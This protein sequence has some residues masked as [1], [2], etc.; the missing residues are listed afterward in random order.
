MET[1]VLRQAKTGGQV[2]AVEPADA[3]L[4]QFDL[5]LDCLAGRAEFP[6]SLEQEVSPTR[7]AIRAKQSVFKGEWQ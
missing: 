5:L 1:G 7:W 6:L 2:E 4:D 3:S